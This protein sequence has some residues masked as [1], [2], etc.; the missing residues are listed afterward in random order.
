VLILG[1]GGRALAIREH[2]ERRRMTVIGHL[3]EEGAG[4]KDHVVGAYSDLAAILRE[5]VVDCVVVAVSP[6][7]ARRVVTD[8]LRVSERVGVP[9]SCEAS[10]AGFLGQQRLVGGKHLV[11][12][13][14]LRPPSGIRV[15][16]KLLFDR[17]LAA[18]MVLLGL[19]L[20]PLL[21]LLIKLD[22]KGPVI[23]KQIRVRNNGR[24]FHLFKFR[25]MVANAEELKAKLMAQNEVD[26]PAFKIA[27]D[28]RITRIGAV[29]RHFRMD[30]LPQLFNI[31][32]GEM[33]F[34]GPRPP[35][36]SEVERYEDWYLRRLSVI[37][38]L[39]CLWQ[40]EHGPLGIAFADWMRLDLRYID[41]WSL[42]LDLRIFLRTIPLVL[43]GVRA[44]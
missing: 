30:E 43:F 11:P 29:L 35:L 3:T 36:P 40:L 2:L 12:I 27:G 44:M 25:T 22:S 28:P 19:P 1:A 10:L 24:H 32:R 38:G 41:N 16:I 14:V 42:W 21:A 4:S 37:P 18:L 6:D 13:G 7:G 15:Q 23:F 26:G 9:V 17:L 20:F 8:V 39:T 31:V 33:S 5:E 34:V